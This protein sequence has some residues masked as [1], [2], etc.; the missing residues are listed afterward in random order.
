LLLLAACSSFK[1][2]KLQTDDDVKEKMRR[3]KLEEEA[4]AAE[5]EAEEMNLLARNVKV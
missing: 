1:Q 2:A 4:E 5:E 3:E